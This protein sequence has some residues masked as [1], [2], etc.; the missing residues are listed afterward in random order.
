MSV[1][2]CGHPA[3]PKLLCDGQTPFPPFTLNESPVHGVD[4]DHVMPIY[5]LVGE[6]KG[7]LFSLH[8]LAF[9]C[10]FPDF[11]SFCGDW[12]FHLTLKL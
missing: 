10:L 4:L 9:C 3:L 7:C 12:G 1:H 6:F 8:P 11:L 5:P 2:Q